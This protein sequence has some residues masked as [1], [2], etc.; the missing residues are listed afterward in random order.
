MTERAAIMGAGRHGEFSIDGKAVRGMTQYRRD[1]LV[2][3]G[4]QDGW[5]GRIGRD[6]DGDLA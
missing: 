2:N 3:R 5:A 1:A 6:E 4:Q